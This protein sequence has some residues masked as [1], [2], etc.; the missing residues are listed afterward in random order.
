MLVW[1]CTFGILREQ[2]CTRSQATLGRD[3]ISWESPRGSRSPCTQLLSVGATKAPPE[4]GETINVDAY[5]MAECPEQPIL[6]RLKKN[7]KTELYPF[8]ISFQAGSSSFQIT[9]ASPMTFSNSRILRSQIKC[10]YYKFMTDS[11]IFY[12]LSV[13]CAFCTICEVHVPETD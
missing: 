8:W 9:V 1:V 4:A 7:Q 13:F 12:G 11:C 2:T 10:I 6:E 3:L 5:L